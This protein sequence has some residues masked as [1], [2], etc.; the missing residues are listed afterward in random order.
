M[1]TMPRGSSLP[2]LGPRCVA[3]AGQK[4]G[5]ARRLHNISR[6]LGACSKVWSLP[7][8]PPTQ[9]SVFAVGAVER[10]KG[11]QKART[12]AVK[13]AQDSPEEMIK[14]VPTQESC[15]SSVE[16]HPH[17]RISD[18]LRLIADPPAVRRRTSSTQTANLCVVSAGGQCRSR[19]PCQ[20][21]TRGQR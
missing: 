19:N 14:R 13:Q 4:V 7:L 3:W 6:A 21:P 17:H 12:M 11:S 8:H 9:P 10:A 16:G 5:N 15:A 20:T 1:A 18:R 2:A